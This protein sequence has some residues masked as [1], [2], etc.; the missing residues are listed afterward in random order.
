MSASNPKNGPGSLRGVKR[1]GQ[2]AAIALVALALTALPGGGGALRVAL[3]VLS[4]FF[5]SAVAFMGYRLFHQF[6]FE[7]ESLEDRQRLVLYGSVGLAFLTICASQRMFDSGGF[8]V[9]AWFALLGIC[10]YGLYWVWV[11]YRRYA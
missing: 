7:L 9:L 5:F 8:G 11:G 6:R 1:A 10:A 4:L 3:T 2:I